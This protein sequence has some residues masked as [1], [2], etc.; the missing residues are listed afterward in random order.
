MTTAWTTSA[1]L[2]EV[3][4][5]LRPRRRIV[6]TTH[7][8]PDGDAIGS[9]LALVRALNHPGPWNPRPRAEA[10]YFGP[11][12]A[13]LADIAG[14]TPHRVLAPNEAPPDDPAIDA[15]CV[16]DTGSW[17]QLEQ[18]RVFLASRS[19]MTAIV[20]HHMHGDA[21]VARRRHI[22]TG[23]AAACQP[24]AELCRLLL[25]ADSLSAL[26]RAVA[27]PLYLGL[28]TDTG[29]FRHSNVSRA[30]MET[31]GELLAAGADSAHLHQVVEQ[32]ESP[33]R[34]RLLAR[35]LASLE[36]FEHD[37]LAVMTL[38]R[39]D[40]HETRAQPGESGGFV[41]FGQTLR[42]VLVT[43]LLTE[44]EP[45]EAPGGKGPLT[46]ISLR[47]KPDTV[48]V[49]QVARAIGGGGHVQAAGA[50]MPLDLDATRR[51]V[52]RLIAAALRS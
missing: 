34:L 36:L 44:A 27:E 2:A 29:W 30:V 19:D 49:N 14:D 10:W 1:S 21:D 9:T 7:V 43:C 26:P 15:V 38:R 31:A 3:S 23:A 11:P 18:L 46:K 17:A 25:G 45:A 40:Y 50:R 33:S 41:D 47:S 12:P 13:W 20:D 52:V 48:D 37:R 32:R 35:A 24:V 22:E 4:E 28:A 51:E 39:A 8:K 6:V 5:F 16:L 42:T